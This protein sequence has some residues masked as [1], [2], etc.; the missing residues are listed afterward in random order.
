M[1]FAI[2]AARRYLAQRRLHMVSP[3]E[4]DSRKEVQD[5]INRINEAW[6]GG[7]TGE[8][9]EYFHNDMVIRGPDLTELARGRET[10]VKSYEDF[11]QKSLVRNF[12]ASEPEVDL[13][14]GMAVATS[15]WAITYELQGQAYQEL[16]RDL[17]VLTR[18]GGRWLVIWR[19]VL[20]SPQP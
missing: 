12:K 9:N 8:L 20:L 11:V 3:A 6:L 7:R 16:G 10:C 14:D 17:F 15:S 2:S 4:G 13:W 5:L 18:A 19:A 1:K